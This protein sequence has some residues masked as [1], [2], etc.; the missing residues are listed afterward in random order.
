MISP[1]SYAAGAPRA[2]WIPDPPKYCSKD[3]AATLRMPYVAHANT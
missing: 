1:A 3:R 2:G